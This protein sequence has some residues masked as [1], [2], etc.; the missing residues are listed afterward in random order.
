MLKLY[1]DA[2]SRSFLLPEGG[3]G[4]FDEEV[5]ASRPERYRQEVMLLQK[6]LGVVPDGIIG[7]KTRAAAEELYMRGR[8][9][10]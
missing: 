3:V 8:I 6:A 2:P 5:S 9:G 7:P 4:N 10:S 1:K